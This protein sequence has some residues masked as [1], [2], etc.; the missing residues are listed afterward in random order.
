[1]ATTQLHR[2]AALPSGLPRL[3]P[4]V[5]LLSPGSILGVLA[6]LPSST[7]KWSVE[8][9]IPHKQN[10]KKLEVISKR[11]Q[12]MRTLKW[13]R[14]SHF[15]AGAASYA[16]PLQWK[17]DPSEALLESK[18]AYLAGFFDGDGCMSGL[19]DLSGCRLTVGQRASA[20]EVLLLFLRCF[21]GTICLLRSGEG[22]RQP[23]LRWVVY[24]CRARSAAASLAI[25]SLTKREQLQIAAAGLSQ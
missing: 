19:T 8:T 3:F 4:L 16:L 5:F 24:G 14:I 2:S 18:R 9:S 23:M 1:M 12:T 6:C 21:G 13:P 17:E 15:E 7:A 11:L 25:F 10:L 22:M 20:A